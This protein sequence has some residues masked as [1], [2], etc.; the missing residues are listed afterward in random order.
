[1]WRRLVTILAWAYPIALLLSI[2]VM[3]FG[4]ARFWQADL[5]LYAP[6]FLFGLPWPVLVVLLLVTRRRYLLWTQALAALIVLFPLMGLVLPTG[7]VR[8]RTDIAVVSILTYNGNFAWGGQ[9]A[10]AAQVREFSPDIVLFQQLYYSDRL[11]IALKRDYREF[12]N[13]G[14]FFIA[15]RFPIRSTTHPDAL[16]YRG[17]LRSTRFLRYELDTAF[18]PIA[19][20]SVHPISPRYQFQIARRGGIRSAIMSGTLLSP[21][22]RDDIESDS[23]L[24]ALQIRRFVAMAAGEDIPTIVAGDTNLPGLSPALDAFASFRDGFAAAGS[25]FGYTFPNPHP[26]MRIDR[27]YVNQRLRFDD[28]RVGTSQASDHRC[29]FAKFT[30]S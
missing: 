11:A 4:S 20:Y 26:W 27:I 1:M 14:E 12:Q 2:V 16:P 18:G 30:V 13:D 6:R 28:F 8:P 10:L 24:R 7:G 15:S 29:V 23:G 17:R 3:R 21:A 5:A 9:D 22:P 19:V 25:G